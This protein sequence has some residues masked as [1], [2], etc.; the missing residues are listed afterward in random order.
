MRAILRELRSLE[1]E[2]DLAEYTP[3]D[4]SN[5]GTWVRALI[6]PE[7]DVGTEAFD[8]LICTPDWLRAP[9]NVVCG[10]IRC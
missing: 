1:V 10:D 3:E 8:I 5:F 9:A 2:G 6:G 7:H 4:P